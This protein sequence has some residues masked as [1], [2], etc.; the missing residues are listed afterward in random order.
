MYDIILRGIFQLVKCR[1]HIDFYQLG[2]TLSQL[3][4]ILAA[5]IFAN[6]FVEFVS[7]HTYRFIGNDTAQRYNG[8]LGRT[9]S[10][11]DNHIALGSFYIDTHTDSGSHRFINHIYVPATHML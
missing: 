10:Y 8:D 7:C 4:I 1:T 11:I 9:A 3:D 6:I 5:H 2:S